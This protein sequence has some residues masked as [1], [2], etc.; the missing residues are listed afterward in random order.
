MDQTRLPRIGDSRALRALGVLTVLGGVWFAL[1]VAVRPEVP[2]AIDWILIGVAHALSVPVCWQVATAPALS[3]NARRYWRWATYALA[4]IGVAMLLRLLD[5]LVRADLSV[6]AEI[7]HGLGAMLIFWALFR[8]PMTQRTGSARRALWLDFSITVVA[9]AIFLWRGAALDL[10]RNH[11]DAPVTI[12]ITAAM[13]I[14]GLTSAFLVAKVALTGSD[15]LSLRAVRLVGV[16][17][18]VGGLGSAATTAFAGR[19]GV[20]SLALVVIPVAAALTALAARCQ[21]VVSSRPAPTRSRRR[22]YSLLPYVAVAAVDGLLLHTV[23]GA[24]SGALTVAIAAVLLTGLVIY[25]QVDAFRENHNLVTRRDAGLLELR[26]EEERFRLLVQ[27]STDI[28]VI[29]ERDSRIRYVTPSVD[30]VLGLDP[31]ALTGKVLGLLLHPDDRPGVQTALTPMLAAAGSSVTFQARFA[32]ADGSWRRLELIASNLTH[33]PSVAGIVTNAR[34]ITETREVQDRLSWAA[35]HDVLT[36]LANRAL[37][38]EA[39]ARSVTDPDP[40]HRMSVV[41]IDLDDFKTVN[42]TLGHAAGDALLVAVAERMRQSVRPGDTVA[43]LGG[44]EFA[45]LLEGLGDEQVDRALVRLAE[46]LLVPV[47]VDDHLLS[48]RASFGVVTGRPGDE[49]GELLRRADIAMYEAKARGEGGHQRYRPGMEARGA[50]RSRLNTALRTALERG[51]LVLHYQPVVS[52]PGGGITGVEALVRWQHPER[53]LLGP[54]DFIPGAEQSGLIVE[55]GRW[56]LGEA[57]RQAA[58]WRAAYGSGAPGPMSVNVSSRQLQ[59]T[60]FAA[61]VAATLQSHDLPA[62]ALTIEITELTAVGGGTTQQTLRALRE[63]GVR[64]A[65]DDFGT[66]ASTL[67]LLAS[68]PVDQIKL[69]RSFVAGSTAI[70]Q[71]VVQLARALGVEAVAKGVETA[72]HADRLAALGYEQAQGYHF[73]RPLPAAELSERLRTR[74]VSRA[75]RS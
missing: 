43:R 69:D 13:M 46:S 48:V 39:V 33:E 10:L 59:E 7:V 15:V 54:G 21:L 2:Y 44:D 35:A 71:A 49:V 62:G 19:P 72:G 16:A 8:L 64:L 73:A 40:R 22:H 27:N 61:E 23:S 18:T 66:G 55:L 52:L 12:V 74:P 3:R 68:C 41:L 26:H 5:A 6:A 58:A 29:T 51:E 34:D 56:V 32:H 20:D 28:V 65:L 24:R 60:G 50:E 14:V 70:A 1:R 53:G 45:L 17:Y 11:G 42:D 4:V 47:V 63:L 30:R 57:C 37:F 9:A 75:A 31:A 36:G 25:R 67:S 38:G